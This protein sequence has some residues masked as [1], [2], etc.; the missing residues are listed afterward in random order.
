MKK[1]QFQAIEKPQVTVECVGHSISSPI[2]QSAKKNPN[3][4]EPWAMFDLVSD[5]FSHYVAKGQLNLV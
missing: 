2:A 1:I 3:F 5:Q 4:D